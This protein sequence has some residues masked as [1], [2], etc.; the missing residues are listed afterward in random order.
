M[1][2]M[3]Q[4]MEG[5]RAG[6]LG[7]ESRFVA[8]GYEIDVR[9]FTQGTLDRSEGAQHRGLV[10][11]ASSSGGVEHHTMSV[12]ADFEAFHQVELL[13]DGERRPEL[14]DGASFPMPRDLYRT[15]KPALDWFIDTY[16]PD[17]TR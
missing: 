10:L 15:M 3:I 14:T 6:I 8:R 5:L 7:E 9:P 4:Q 1:G 16:L 17:T 11:T 2:T 12:E 13:V